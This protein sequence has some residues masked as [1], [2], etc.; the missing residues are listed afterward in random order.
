MSA[1]EGNLTNATINNRV[2]KRDEY[3]GETLVRHLWRRGYFCI[4][5]RVALAK[6][7]LTLRYIVGLLQRLL[8]NVSN[9][10]LRAS[11][12]KLNVL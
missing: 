11:S 7:R 4:R 12:A 5:R 1:G 8:R 6:P 3:G 10:F 2:P 9:S